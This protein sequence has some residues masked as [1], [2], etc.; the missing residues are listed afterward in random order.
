MT[1]RKPSNYHRNGSSGKLITL[2]EVVDY[3]V[4][5]CEILDQVIGALR[6]TGTQTLTPP[7]PIKTVD[8]KCRFM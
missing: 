8:P 3:D 2:A 5:T 7:S 1:V 6:K 4:E